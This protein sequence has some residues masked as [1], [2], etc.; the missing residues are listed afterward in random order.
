VFLYSI[1][2]TKQDYIEHQVMVDTNNIKAQIHDMIVTKKSATLNLSILIA[3]NTSVATQIENGNFKILNRVKESVSSNMDQYDNIWIQYLSTDAKSR[4]QTWRENEVA[5]PFKAL[6]DHA[7]FL[8]KG[9]PKS[10]AFM[11]INR[12]DLTFNG[13]SPLYNSKGKLLGYIEVMTHFNSID[14]VL[15]NRSIESA[16]LVDAR[17]TS[18]LQ[19][20]FSNTFVQ[21]HYVANINANKSILQLIE[22]TG[23]T[24]LETI[25]PFEMVGNYYVVKYPIYN[26]QNERIAVYYAFI[27]RDYFKDVEALETKA[28]YLIASFIAVYLTFFILLFRMSQNV[29]HQMLLARNYKKTSTKEKQVAKDEM[30][31]SLYIDTLTGAF[32]RAKLDED[33]RSLGD[34]AILI[35]NIDN[36]SHINS[37][38]GF[39]IGDALLSKVVE[40]L[41]QVT[42]NRIYRIN[43]DE[44]IIFERNYLELIEVIKSSFVQVPLEVDGLQ[45]RLRFSFGVHLSSSG[46]ARIREATTALKKAKKLGKNR[47]VVYEEENLQK[48]R[49]FVQ[50]NDILFNAIEHNQ[51][52]PFFQGIRDNATG[53]IVKYEALARIVNGDE[54]YTPSEFSEVAKVGGFLMDITKIIIEK[55]LPFLKENSLELSINITEDDLQSDYLID[56]LQHHCRI[57]EIES[58]RITL[59]IVEGI[60]TA[61]TQRH[62]EQLSVLKKCGFKIALD[63]FGVEYS[64]FERV[65]QL[66]IDYIKIDGKYI[67]EIVTNE[68]Y[69]KI[70]A[71]IVYFA[72]SIGLDVIVEY[73]ESQ[74]IQDIIDALEVEFSQGYL[75]S[76]PEPLIKE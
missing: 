19:E 63:D 67:K 13:I 76:Q 48:R 26:M 3:N 58:S 51:I 22:A 55:S 61:E 36:F 72:K 23:V 65:A 27:N 54:V 50:F 74:E 42:S 4:Y 5:S 47:Y 41:R 66:D 6:H 7:D 46:R 57:N 75:F 52:V 10:Y 21:N 37:Y 43:G 34:T 62:L 53:K 56:Y 31:E 60:S 2:A 24:L 73:V 69:F 35:L 29:S 11:E 68:K 8:Q 71:S 38:Y 49:Q 12:Y 39:R 15:K 64:N 17:F 1:F 16:V 25:K 20:T 14:K 18:E 30:R 33:M 70:V 28:N 9:N 59:E 32:K 44:F 45:F 40:R